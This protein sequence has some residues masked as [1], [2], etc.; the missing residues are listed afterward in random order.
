MLLLI[1]ATTLVAV[2]LLSVRERIRDYGVLEAIGLTPRQ[3]VSTVVSS[4]TALAVLASLVAIPIGIG[5]YLTLVRIASGTTEDAVIAPWW[6][7]ALIPIGTVVVVVV[8]VCGDRS[9][10]L[11]RHPNPHCRRAPLRV[12]RGP[13][14]SRH[15]IPEV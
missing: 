6:S 1:T 11:A 2:A 12:S 9:S 3:L 14:R 15:F 13:R 7:L 10:C 5:L 8:V 4:H